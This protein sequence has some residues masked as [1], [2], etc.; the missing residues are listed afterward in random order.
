MLTLSKKYECCSRR[1]RTKSAIWRKIRYYTSNWRDTGALLAS[2]QANANAVPLPAYLQQHLPVSVQQANSRQVHRALLDYLRAVPGA[3]THR[4]GPGLIS[5]TGGQSDIIV[6]R[7]GMF[8]FDPYVT[9]L[10]ASANPP[11]FPLAKVLKPTPRLTNADNV[12]PQLLVASVG[13]QLW[14]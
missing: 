7:A 13:V 12:S 4:L 3:A 6:A 2:M 14:G 8:C 10:A 5:C 1:W 9:A 11:A